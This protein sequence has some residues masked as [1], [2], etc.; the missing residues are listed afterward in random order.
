M[1]RIFISEPILVILDLDKEMQVEVDVSDY[2]M[3]EVLLVKC[4]DGRQRPV[5][6]ISKSINLTE[7]NYK[8]HNK[9]ILIVIRC[10]EAQRYYLEETKVQ[11]KI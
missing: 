10:L 3:E 8:I 6:F 7:R 1:K 5:V 9:E 4:K 11:F 2:A